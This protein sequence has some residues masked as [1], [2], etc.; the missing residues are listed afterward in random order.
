MQQS[1]LSIDTPAACGLR[2]YENW[3]LLVLKQNVAGVSKEFAE[4]VFDIF[5]NQCTS[6]HFRNNPD[7]DLE[8]SKQIIVGSE[9]VIWAKNIRSAL[10]DAASEILGQAMLLVFQFRL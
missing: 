1:H 9:D 6:Y 10:L 3:V 4:P 8:I 2:G 5:C 7:L